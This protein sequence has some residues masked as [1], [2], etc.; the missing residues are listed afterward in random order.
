MYSSDSSN[1]SILNHVLKETSAIS[2]FLSMSRLLGENWSP[3]YILVPLSSSVSFFLV[4]SSE[5]TGADLV[6]E[7]Q[8]NFCNLINSGKVLTIGARTGPHDTI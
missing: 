1:E 5:G 7:A 6:Q 8:L 4:S 2:S 3:R